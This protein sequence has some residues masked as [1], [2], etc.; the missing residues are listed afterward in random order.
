MLLQT[1]YFVDQIFRGSNWS[2]TD[3]GERLLASTQ[4]QFDNAGYF[5][6]KDNEKFFECL[7]LK[8]IHSEKKF[9]EKSS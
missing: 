2:P 3:I 4:S 6:L 8:F 9:C 7:I 1:D 5:Y